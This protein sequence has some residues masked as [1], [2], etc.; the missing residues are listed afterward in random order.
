ME[1]EISTDFPSALKEW[2]ENLGLT[3]T[4]LARRIGVTYSALFHYEAGNANPSTLAAKALAE[5]GFPPEKIPAC[6]S[7]KNLPGFP[8]ALEKWR[9]RLGLTQAEL[10]K[11]INVSRQCITEYESGITTP[12]VQIAKALTKLGFPL[13]EIPANCKNI[14]RTSNCVM[15]DEERDFAEIR[16]GLVLSFLKCYSLNEHEWYDVAVFG[17][18]HAVQLWFRRND[19]HRYSFSTIAYSCMRNFVWRER[20]KASR[21][22]KT[23]SI[24]EVIPGTEDFTYRDMLCDPR[25]CVGI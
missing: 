2:R 3:K 22:P 14:I 7:V 19:L 10:A 13:E 21:R 4:E 20:K 18:L 11:R 25:D 8:G 23:V 16:H 9:K 1:K 6:R 17:Y 15:T 12:S 5:L 24:D